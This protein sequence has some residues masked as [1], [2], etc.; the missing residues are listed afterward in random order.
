MRCSSRLQKRPLDHTRKEKSQMAHI[1]LTG[2]V[3]L[4]TGANNPM[5]IGAAS[6]RALARAGVKVFITYL[7]V[8]PE[9][10]CPSAAAGQQP[11]V[12]DGEQPSEPGWALYSFMRMKHPDEVIEAIRRE[13]G[14]AA[15]WEADLANVETVPALFGRAESAFGPVDI[16]INNAAHC[17]AA[18]TLDALTASM[19]DRSYA[20]NLRAP[21]LLTA[22][23]L[24]RYKHH[25]LKWGRIVNLS[26]G[27]AQHFV[28]QIAYGASK[29]ALEAA[30]RA[31]ATAVGAL[32]ITVNAIAPGPIQTGYISPQSEQDLLC[33]TPAGRL[34]QPEDVANAIAFLC[35]DHAD[36]ISGQVL[37]VTG[38]RDLG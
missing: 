8:P 7:R 19:I 13:G 18:D 15:A 24:R 23:Y 32:G 37:R 20:I 25:R 38:G 28:T 31:I 6:A 17:C 34:G 10:E 12:P 14:T 36:Y 4:V 3:A 11:Y 2:K 35:S 21:L 26:T 5:G 30:T 33:A 1:D 29:A 16:L 22:E 9:Q 27:P